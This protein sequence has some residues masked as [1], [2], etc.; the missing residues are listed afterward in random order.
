MSKWKT[1]RLVQPPRVTCAG[2][3]RADYF[4]VH[5][6]TTTGC[7]GAVIATVG[8]Y[9]TGC[10]ECSRSREPIELPIQFFDPMYMDVDPIFW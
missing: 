7:Q 9:P 6:Y 4:L 2:T 3:T 8:L 1:Y 5:S 10:S